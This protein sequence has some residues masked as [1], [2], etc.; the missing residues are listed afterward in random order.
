MHAIAVGHGK[1]CHYNQAKS[2][3]DHGLVVSNAEIIGSFGVA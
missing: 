3:D 1:N 2:A